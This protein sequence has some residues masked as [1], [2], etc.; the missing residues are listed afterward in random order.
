[1]AT[2][3]VVLRRT[4]PQWDSALFMK[5]VRLGRSWL[6]GVTLAS[7]VTRVAHPSVLSHE[8]SAA[9]EAT[10]SVRVTCQSNAADRGFQHRASGPLMP[11]YSSYAHP[12]NVALLISRP[13]VDPA[14]PM[15]II[16]Q[17][18]GLQISRNRSYYR[19]G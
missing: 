16:D 8:L 4:G 19:V 2:F 6:V 3:F 14:L 7:V 17:L 18:R 15:M 11:D 1:V 12:P 10:N 13:V 5:A 9:A